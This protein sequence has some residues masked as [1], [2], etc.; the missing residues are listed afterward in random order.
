MLEQ[1]TQ[2]F[3][4][5]GI[6]GLFG[7]A[8]LDSFIS[9]IPPFFMQI[10]MSLIDPGS[11]LRYATVAFTASI[12]GAPIGFML[13]KWLG[14]PLLE[15]LLPEK[16]VVLATEKFAKNG[17][18]AVLIGAFTPIPFKV[19]T[20]LSGVF[21]Y[22]LTKLMFFAIVGR[23][24]KFFLIGTLFHFYGKHAKVLL[25]DYLEVTLLGVA[26]MVAIAWF[27]W[28]KRRKRYAMK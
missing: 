24:L 19:F 20:I 17:D 22:S 11:A 28:N 7:M 25:D 18:A 8:F 5:Y 21:N 2:L 16:W 27:I 3:M 1:I 9:P 4:N 14:K 12:L 26:A 6:W 15:K 23:G 10:A 13:G